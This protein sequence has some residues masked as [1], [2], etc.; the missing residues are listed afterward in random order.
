LVRRHDGLSWAI[1]TNTNANLAGKSFATMI[2][3]PMH[4]AVDQAMPLAQNDLFQSFGYKP[5]N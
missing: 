2:D 3:G 4:K 1:L 5:A